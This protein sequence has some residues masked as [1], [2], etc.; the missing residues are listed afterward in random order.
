M[1]EKISIH[2]ELA[3]AP[4]G[5]F[6]QAVKFG[7]T[8]HISGQLPLDPKTGRPI[9]GDMK[10][11][12]KRALDNLAAVVQGA[13]AEMSHILSTRLYLVD[14]REFPIFDAVSKDYFFFLPPARTTVQVSGLP[15]GCRVCIDAI[16]EIKEPDIKGSGM[17]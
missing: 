13:G 10:A 4:F 1:P 15:G 7:H 6:A 3:P 8:V 14:L 17:L 12:C 11:Q 16:L 9:E 2:A 5:H